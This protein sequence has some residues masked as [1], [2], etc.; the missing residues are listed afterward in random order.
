M[1]LIYVSKLLLMLILI[2]QMI[3]NR[4]QPL[5]LA[6]LQIVFWEK[7]FKKKGHQRWMAVSNNDTASLQA[8]ERKRNL[9]L[10]IK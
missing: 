10:T 2:Y 7:T 6:I 1:K 9:K 4:I 5:S 3:S 8:Q